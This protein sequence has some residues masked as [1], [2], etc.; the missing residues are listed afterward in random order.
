M[1]ESTRV[2]N[3]AP[4]PGESPIKRPAALWARRPAEWGALRLETPLEPAAVEKERPAKARWLESL[5][6]FPRAL[7]E[8]KL[9]RQSTPR[10][11][12]MKERPAAHRCQRLAPGQKQLVDPITPSTGSHQPPRGYPE[13]W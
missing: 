2:V 3:P 9:Q 7:S 1:P 10:H 13:D 4:R 11:L 5:A 12:R 6:S 8:W